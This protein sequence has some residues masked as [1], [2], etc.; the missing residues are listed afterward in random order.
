VSGRPGLAAVL[1]AAAGLRPARLA[2]AEPSPVSDAAHYLNRARQLLAHGQLAHPEPT[3]CTLPGH[4]AFVFSAP[5]F[6]S[7]NLFSP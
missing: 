7:E 6:L 2:Y 1:P 4:P 3:A 5:L